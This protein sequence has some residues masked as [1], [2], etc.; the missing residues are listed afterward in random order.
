MNGWVSIGNATAPFSR[1]DNLVFDSL[2][3]QLCYESRQRTF[4][5]RSATGERGIYQQIVSPL[6][7]CERCRN[8]LSKQFT[9]YFTRWCVF[10]NGFNKKTV[11][12]WE[13]CLNWKLKSFCSLIFRS[14]M[15]FFRRI[16]MK[17]TF[18]MEQSKEIEID[19]VTLLPQP[20]MRSFHL[21]RLC[22]QHSTCHRSAAS[23]HWNTWTGSAILQWKWIRK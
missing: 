9:C 12:R 22:R 6:L 3:Y 20:M 7:Q 8:L 10:L 14:S 21:I 19:A 16:A 4:S 17:V 11:W 23:P 5:Y 2:F 1:S 18:A 15:R 13:K